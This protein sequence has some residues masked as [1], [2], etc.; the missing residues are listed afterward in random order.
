MPHPVARARRLSIR[1]Q[2][3]KAFGGTT[4]VMPS[5]FMDRQTHLTQLKTT[6][7]EAQP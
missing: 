3:R 5:H 2:R 4:V 1:D 7:Q 6:R